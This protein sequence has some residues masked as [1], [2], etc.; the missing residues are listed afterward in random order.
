MG[1]LS[2]ALAVPAGFP[3]SVAVTVAEYAPGWIGEPETIPLLAR[4]SPGGN[5]PP[6]TVQVRGEM[7][8][9]A[10]KVSEY[11]LPISPT[12]NSGRNQEHL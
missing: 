11:R 2:K 9:D 8:P 3:E 7:L 1:K 4:V 5:D 10:L 6:E 12:V